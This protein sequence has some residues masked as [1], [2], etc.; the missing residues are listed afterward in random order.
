LFFGYG[1]FSYRILIEK[2]AKGLG[3]GFV[4]SIF[5]FDNFIKSVPNQYQISTITHIFAL[6][7]A[8]WTDYAFVTH[9]VSHS[10]YQI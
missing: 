8:I 10:F 1:F 3:T 9:T 6:S 2:K 4:L 7:R 5:N